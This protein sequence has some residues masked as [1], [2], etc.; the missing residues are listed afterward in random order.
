M[1][2]D[3]D[4]ER[5]ARTHAA[6]LADELQHHAD[7]AAVHSAYAARFDLAGWADTIREACGAMQDD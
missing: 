2:R 1:T 3:A 7:N 6:A 5:F 4:F